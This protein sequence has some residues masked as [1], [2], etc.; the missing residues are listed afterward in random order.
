MSNSREAGMWE[1]PCPWKD[2]M[3]CTAVRYFWN[4][5][6]QKVLCL[7]KD[8]FVLCSWLWFF[9]CPTWSY[10]IS[11]PKKA[12]IIH[13][14][15]LLP[16]LMLRVNRVELPVYSF[17]PSIWGWFCS[18][19]VPWS[20]SPK[21]WLFPTQCTDSSSQALPHTAVFSFS[22]ALPFST[23]NWSFLDHPSLFSSSF[24]ACC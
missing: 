16:S 13:F 23:H 22:Q 1:K 9:F 15:T 18:N 19:S 7:G 17:S 24:T 5:S 14:P 8:Y 21:W 2:Q 3:R 4:G 12:L 20:M 10:S 6:G 11:L